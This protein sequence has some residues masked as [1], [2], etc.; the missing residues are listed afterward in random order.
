MHL[1]Y[2]AIRIDVILLYEE[3]VIHIEGDW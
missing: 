3:Q 1:Q 2:D